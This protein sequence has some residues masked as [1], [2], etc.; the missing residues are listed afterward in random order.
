MEFKKNKKIVS[1]IKLLSHQG[2]DTDNRFVGCEKF[3]KFLKK[4]P[5]IHSLRVRDSESRGG[6]FEPHVW[7]QNVANLSQKKLLNCQL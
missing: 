4:I 6:G 2:V 7:R 1:K 3:L 5:D